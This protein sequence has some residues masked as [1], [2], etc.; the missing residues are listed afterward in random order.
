MPDYRRLYVPGGSYFFTVVT[1]GRRTLFHNVM[2]QRLLGHAI[3]DCQNEWPFEVSAIVLLP[4]HLH[5]IWNLP[6]GDDKYSRRWSRIKRNFT[7]AWLSVGG[8]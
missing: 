4:D 8:R 3:R 2:P 7:K 1:Q 5:A 6:Q